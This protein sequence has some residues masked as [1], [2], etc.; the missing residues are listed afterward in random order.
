LQH[1]VSLVVFTRKDLATIHER[2][3]KQCALP[4]WRKH[5][6]HLTRQVATAGLGEHQPPNLFFALAPQKG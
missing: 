3:R 1:F 5:H 2:Q 6:N 4:M